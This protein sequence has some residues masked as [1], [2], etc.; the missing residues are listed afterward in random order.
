MEFRF[1][2]TGIK[3]SLSFIAGS[4]ICPI[5]PSLLASIYK[6]CIP[7]K[8]MLKIMGP[9]DT[10]HV[11]DLAWIFRDLSFVRLTNVQKN[12][13]AREKGREKVTT[14][15][16]L[17]KKKKKKTCWMHD[18]LVLFDTYQIR[19]LGWILGT[20]LFTVVLYI[21]YQG[22]LGLPGSI[23]CR[24]CIQVAFFGRCN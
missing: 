16:I 22:D 4:P 7:V 20:S 15:F 5:C 8:K 9:F 14:I 11:K 2:A 3:T 17:K 6:G 23:P 12:D 21:F 24:N 13:G 19:D 10:Y 18:P 1:L